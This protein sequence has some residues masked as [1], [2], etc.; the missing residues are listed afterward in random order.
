MCGKSSLHGVNQSNEFW[1]ALDGQLQGK[2]F[3][4]HHTCFSTVPLWLGR[5]PEFISR[6]KN[7][8]TPNSNLVLH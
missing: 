5:N 4:G 1:A 3:S 2:L 6:R 8:P 7:R